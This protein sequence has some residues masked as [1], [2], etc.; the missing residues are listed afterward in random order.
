MVWIALS[1]AITVLAGIIMLCS[2][3]SETTIGSLPG[4]LLGGSMRQG[5]TRCP[6]GREDYEGYSMMTDLSVWNSL[7]DTILLQ[8]E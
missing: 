4:C 5:F 6:P 7:T 3:S 8:L 2:D 1:S